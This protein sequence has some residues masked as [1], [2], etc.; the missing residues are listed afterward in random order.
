MV[1]T[2]MAAA[3][4]VFGVE[5]FPGFRIFAGDLLTGRITTDLPVS[6]LTW[7]MRLN[8]GG[9]IEVGLK[10]SAKELAGIDIK[11]AT[12]ELKQFIGVAVGDTILEA[13]PAGKGSYDPKA[14][15][16]KVP[17]SG[18]WSIFDK[19]KALNW[20]QILAGTPITET[21][22]SIVS[23]TL[24]SIAAELVRISIQD[25]PDG[26]LPIVLPA[27]VAGINERNYQG[28]SLS[29]TGEMLRNLTG[30]Q[31]GPDIRFRPRYKGGDRQFV[32]W[33]METGSA[34]QP[35]LQ[36]SGD[37]LVWDTSTPRSG[38]TGFGADT[39]GSRLASRVYQPGSGT[40]RDMKLATASS[41]VLLDAGYP[42]TEADVGAKDVEDQGILQANADQLL[43]AGSGT[44]EQWSL[45]VRADQAPMLGSYRPGD[46]ARINVPPWHPILDAGERRVRVMA[47]DGD[48]TLE[49]KLTVAPIRNAGSAY[50]AG[51]TS[52]LD[53]LKRRYPATDLFPGSSVYPL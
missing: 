49:V 14:E 38:V 41:R 39:D 12:A 31:N 35:L 43:D 40:E 10:P 50:G 30:V 7:G 42:Y 52:I 16:F 24:G 2:P 46:W 9:T 25:N 18:I 51:Q 28:F 6:S 47:I 45:T 3:A 20:T 48:H 34:D 32:E 5:Q 8:D 19:R 17:A 44:W 36:Q 29:W 26:Q 37:D 15:T 13:G 11:A 27:Q 4:R 1:V 22:I 33:V 21:Y 23:K 53:G